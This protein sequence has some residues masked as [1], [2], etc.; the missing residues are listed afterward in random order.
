MLN[1]RLKLHAYASMIYRAILSTITETQVLP[2]RQ[3]SAPDPSQVVHN[4]CDIHNFCDKAW[5]II[6]QCEPRQ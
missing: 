2:L 4:V 5:L 1:H 6:G 3:S